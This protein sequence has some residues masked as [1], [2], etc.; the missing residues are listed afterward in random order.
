MLFPLSYY[1]QM[2]AVEECKQATN[3]LAELN[4]LM[5]RCPEYL[6]APTRELIKLFKTT[7]K[8]EK[9]VSPKCFLQLGSLYRMKIVDYLEEQ[10]KTAQRRTQA[11]EQAHARLEALESDPS[12]KKDSHGY[13]MAFRR[14]LK[15][16]H[17]RDVPRSERDVVIGPEEFMYLTQR[18]FAREKKSRLAA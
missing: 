17:V 7:L 3:L 12:L 18:F 8:G 16:N 6:E 9:G 2:K 14:Y 1:Q 4:L 5:R 13:C 11:L 15:G 10:T